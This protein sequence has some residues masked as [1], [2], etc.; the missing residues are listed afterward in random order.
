M[1]NIMALIGNSHGILTAGKIEKHIKVSA[2]K[3]EIIL[4]KNKALIAGINVG[5]SIKT[6]EIMRPIK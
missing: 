3:Y 6:T 1:N 2:D 5:K 4:I